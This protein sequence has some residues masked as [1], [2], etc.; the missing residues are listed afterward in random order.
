[1]KHYVYKYVSHNKV[2][3]VGLTNDITRR[4]LE[5]SSGVGIEEKFI[6]YLN[7]CKIY[8]HECA[9]EVEMRA[10][11]SLLINI[12]KPILNDIDIQDGNSTVE[13]FIEWILY[14]K[15]VGEDDD[16]MRTLISIYEKNIKSNKTRIKSHLQTKAKLIN[17]IERLRPFYEYLDKHKKDIEQMYD[18]YFG[19]SAEIVPYEQ[20]IYIGNI[21]VKHWYENT[22]NQG[23][24]CWVKFSDLFL[25]AFFAI[26]SKSGW[27][28]DTLK[29]IGINRCKEIE[30]MIDNLHRK[31]AELQTQKETLYQ[32][33]SV[34]RL[35]E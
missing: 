32:K 10:L 23:E 3:Y 35:T 24:I 25:K 30:A 5:H 22:E 6:P 16:E 27:I 15:V 28:N 9:N 21:L 13:L 31:N 4:I 34:C 11:E 12:Y 7:D 33:L 19:L 29:V 2:V 26:S 18:S 20:E 8:Y 17:K 14:E 1:M